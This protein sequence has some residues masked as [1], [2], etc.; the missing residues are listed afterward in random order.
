MEIGEAPNRPPGA[1]KETEAGHVK[2][3]DMIRE[4]GATLKTVKHEQEYMQV[5]G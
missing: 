5:N 2:L 4:L 3:E 1:E